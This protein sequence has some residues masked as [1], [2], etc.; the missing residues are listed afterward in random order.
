MVAHHGV[1]MAAATAVVITGVRPG[2]YGVSSRTRATLH[3]EPCDYN[4]KK[5]SK[6]WILPAGGMELLLGLGGV[7]RRPGI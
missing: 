6:P 3:C 7:D 4:L 1:C 2:E 5:K